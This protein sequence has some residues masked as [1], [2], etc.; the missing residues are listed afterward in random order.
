MYKLKFDDLEEEKEEEK[1][2]WLY[3]FSLIYKITPL[4]TL[5]KC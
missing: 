4:F 5:R 2:N 1:N 3:Q